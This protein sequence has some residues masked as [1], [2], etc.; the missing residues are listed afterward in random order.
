MLLSLEVGQQ[1]LPRCQNLKVFFL[2]FEDLFYPITHRLELIRRY[3]PEVD[4]GK[5]TLDKL[6]MG[7]RGGGYKGKVAALG[8]ISLKKLILLI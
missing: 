1:R 3:L 8:Y 2:I 4:S 6:S 7:E 5:L